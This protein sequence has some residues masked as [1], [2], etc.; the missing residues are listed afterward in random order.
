MNACMHGPSDRLT[1]PSGCWVRHLPCSW[2]PRYGANS[3]RRRYCPAGPNTRSGS[4]PSSSHWRHFRAD[5][6]PPTAL[7]RHIT[8][9]WQCSSGKS[10]ERALQAMNRQSRVMQLTI[11]DTE[12]PEQLLAVCARRRHEPIAP[13]GV[14]GRLLRCIP[15]CSECGETSRTKGSASRLRICPIYAASTNADDG[16][17]AISGDVESKTRRAAAG[18]VDWRGAHCG[19]H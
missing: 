15:H 6:C 3:Q 11:V 9:K 1:W 19:R 12:P 10:C 7:Q 8:N 14:D 18:R 4:T 17:A 16:V 2:C 5:T 13:A